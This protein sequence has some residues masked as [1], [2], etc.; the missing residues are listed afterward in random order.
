MVVSILFLLAA[1]VGAAVVAGLG[2]FFFVIRTKNPIGPS[3]VETGGSEPLW[4]VSHVRLPVLRQVSR[5][6]FGCSR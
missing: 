4:I 1:L 2:V 5:P 6:I 3:L